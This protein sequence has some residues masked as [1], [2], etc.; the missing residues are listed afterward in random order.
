MKTLDSIR[1]RRAIKHFDA[2]HS[3]SATE[4]NEFLS[5]AMLSPTAFNIQNWRYVVV[6]DPE[7][8]KQIRA[9]AWGQAQVTD[10]SLF[11]ILCADLKAWE[12]QPLR[13]WVNAQK[14]VQ[15]FMLPAIDNYYR[16]K[17]QVQRDEAM[18]S[19]GI[20]AQ[21]LMLSATA[22]GYDSCPMDG[23]DFAKVAELIHLPDDHVIAMFVAIGKGTQE[24][25]PRPGQ[26]KLDEVMIKNSFASQ[27]L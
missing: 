27:Q 15:D 26:L 13:Y 7:L 12:K 4:I 18:R 24:A 21:T 14:E 9:A 10:A 1:T 5:L 17:D 6:T 3:M 22:L 16:G 25:W 8:R 23:F 19:C 20:A 2:S 11:I